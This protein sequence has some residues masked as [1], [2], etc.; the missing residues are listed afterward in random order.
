MTT[1]HTPAER[2]LQTFRKKPVVIEAMQLDGTM[3]AYDKAIEFVGGAFGGGAFNGHLENTD[4]N[5]SWLYIDTLE[6]QMTAHT[7]DW[8]IRGVKGEHYPCKPDIFAA[9]YEPADT[10]SARPLPS[11]WV[12]DAEPFGHAMYNSKGA[13]VG[14]RQ[15]TGFG[16]NF[17]VA[18]FKRADK[19]MPHGAPHTGRLVYAAPSAPAEGGEDGQRIGVCCYG[20][21]KTKESCAS[22]TAWKPA[23]EPLAQG[24]VAWVTPEALKHL[25]KQSGVAKVD[26]WNCASGSERVPLYASPQPAAEV[27][28]PAFDQ[29]GFGLACTIGWTELVK[30]MRADGHDVKDSSGPNTRKWMEE[31]VRD[32][33]APLP[34]PPQPSA[35]VGERARELLAKEYRGHRWHE[36]AARLCMGGDVT[37]FVEDDALRVIARLIE[38]G[39]E[40]THVITEMGR[41][42][43]AIAIIMKGPEPAGT[44]WSYHDL[45]G[46]VAS[47]LSEPRQ[48]AAE[49]KAWAHTKMAEQGSSRRDKMMVAEWAKRLLPESS[50]PIKDF[51][52]EGMSITKEAA[53]EAVKQVAI[54]SALTTA[55]GGSGLRELIKRWRVSAKICG[56]T[57]YSDGA[58][59][60]F[61]EC[62][63]ELEA[64]LGRGGRG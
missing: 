36:D 47:A 14:F 56:E 13:C 59:D 27:T 50:F 37:S 49:M 8:I 63:D 48:V 40:D 7:G 26:A 44:A 61:S 33:F 5:K 57:E 32:T 20:G 53:R 2:G 55:A 25:A 15:N 23:P 22:C 60:A 28:K 64:A 38:E 34:N 31:I 12:A 1:T 10:S 51:D 42:L 30:A 11:D 54:E 52:V 3:E 29:K 18:D 45:P 9:T 24:V 21:R 46:L 16:Y 43:A 19:I 17:T 39:D 6:G 4:P 35:S 41:L 58:R 62:A